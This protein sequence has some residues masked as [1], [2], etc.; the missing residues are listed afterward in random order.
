[1]LYM[2]VI[3]IIE[4]II[5]EKVKTSDTIEII[6]CM[7]EMKTGI[8]PSQQRLIFAGKRLEGDRTIDQY[9][10]KD[11]STMHVVKGLRGC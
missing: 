11:G 4:P 8:P 7:V 2:K 5:L 10:I 1:M 3:D 9:N 6:K